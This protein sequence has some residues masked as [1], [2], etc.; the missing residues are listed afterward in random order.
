MIVSIAAAALVAAGCSG[1]KESQRK[2]TPHQMG[3]TPAASA[4]VAWTVPEGW[5]KE[6][7][8][9]SMRKAQFALAA[10]EGDSDGAEVVI[11]FF[12][13][14]GQVGG[15]EANINRW[16]GQMTQPDGTP[17][18][19]VAEVE[20]STVNGMKQIRVEMTGTYSGMMMSSHGDAGKPG[21]KMVSTIVQSSAGPYFVKMVGP[22]A[23]V[24]KWEESYDAFLASFKEG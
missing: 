14:E 16:Y 3:E 12:P 13:G 8:T 10:A 11:T 9:N 2:E 20:R 7:P 17:T 1:D 19:E 24:N 15:E 4:E 6:E 21:Y 18:S 5:V 23:T 22:E